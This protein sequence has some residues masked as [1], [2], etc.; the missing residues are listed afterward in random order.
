MEL[1][2]TMCFIKR[3]D[4]VLLLLRT[5][6][7][8]NGK[9]N[10]VGG[11]IEKDE[12]PLASVIRETREESGLIINDMT[13]RGIVTWNKRTGMYVYVGNDF[14]GSLMKDGPEGKLEWKSKEWIVSS[15]EVV[16]NI[17][18]FLDELFSKNE[19]VEH[20]FMYNSTGNITE[21]DVIGLNHEVIIAATT[22]V[23]S[24]EEKIYAN[25]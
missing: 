6:D 15:S 20:S 9:W 4:T 8:N 21:Y 1:P 23:K 2:Y 14:E 24:I 7:P 19:P 13:F 11:K 10:G 3:K 17:K 25:Y 18:F 16:S 12:T 5:K 22:K